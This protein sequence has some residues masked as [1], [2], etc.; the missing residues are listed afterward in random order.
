MDLGDQGHVG[1]V[2]ADVVEHEDEQVLVDGVEYRVEEKMGK[3]L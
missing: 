2:P 3:M 1:V